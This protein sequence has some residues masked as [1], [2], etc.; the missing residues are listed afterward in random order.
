MRRISAAERVR[1]FAN[2]MEAAIDSLQEMV[3]V[4]GILQR[5]PLPG[6]LK[7]QSRAIE[8]IELNEGFSRKDLVDAAVV[9]ANNPPVA[10]MYLSIKNDSEGM[11][12]D[13]LLSEMEKLQMYNQLTE[14][15]MYN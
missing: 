7:I 15:T 5:D 11:R 12:R 2:S 13:F 3:R 4:T 1:T 14:N 9:I 10:L 6:V 8:A